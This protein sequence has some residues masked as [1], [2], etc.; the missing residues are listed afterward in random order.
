[1]GVNPQGEY[2]QWPIVTEV[3]VGG[4][5]SDPYYMYEISGE[6]A[7]YYDAPAIQSRY[8]SFDGVHEVLEQDFSYST[9]WSSGS[10]TLPIQDW[11]QKTTTVKTTDLVRGTSYS[12]IY[13]YGPQW[14]GI[15]PGAH[16]GLQVEVPVESQIQYYDTTGSL[17][18]TV[19]KQWGNERIITQQTTQLGNEI[20]E[21]DWQY[22]PTSSFYPSPQSG[23]TYSSTTGMEQYRWDY[24]YG[25]GGHGPLLRE[26]YIPSYD[27]SFSQFIVDRPNSVEVLNGSGSV[28][29]ERSYVYDGNGNLTSRSDWVNTSGSP[30]LTTGHTY[31]AYGN[32]ISTTDP[33]GN[34][35]GYSYQ[36]SFVDSCSYSPAPGAY[37]TQ[38]TYPATNGIQ[39]Q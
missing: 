12:T 16:Q 14:S 1:M 10:G 36:N 19:T 11:T 13:T 18:K 27:N 9:S 28:V 3:N 7:Y 23:W 31:D 15:Q 37:L 29:A 39:H 21:T 22:Y 4:T 32:I 26:T 24:D 6:C 8:V 17:L 30:V 38:I 20:A 2:G 33:A 25:S 5:L 35:T 34:V